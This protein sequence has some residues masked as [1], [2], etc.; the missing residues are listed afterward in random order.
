MNKP[1][2]VTIELICNSTTLTVLRD[3]LNQA[4]TIQAEHFILTIEQS[5]EQSI[6]SHCD[7]RI[8]P[9]MDTIKVDL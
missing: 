9:L 7:I 1:L 4:L 5:Q 3:S 8:L 2:T 6:N